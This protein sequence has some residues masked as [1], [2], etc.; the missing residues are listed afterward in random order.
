VQFKRVV[1]S[2]GSFDCTS[3]SALRRKCV[4]HGPIKLAG[5]NVETIENVT[6]E[7]AVEKIG[8]PDKILWAYSVYGL[9][10]LPLFDFSVMHLYQVYQMLGGISRIATLSELYALPAIYVEACEIITEELKNAES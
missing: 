7:N 9:C 3:C 5:P 2:S 6:I 10:P 1:A 4:L 8:G